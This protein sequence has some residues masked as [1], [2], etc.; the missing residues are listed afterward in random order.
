MICN[1]ISFSSKKDA[2]NY[3]NGKKEHSYNRPL[4]SK[5][6]FYL[7]NECNNWHLTSMTKKQIKSFKNKIKS[8]GIKLG[9]IKTIKAALLR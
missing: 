9:Y 8:F 5:I 3:A 2:K 7:C 1:K 6:K 4:G